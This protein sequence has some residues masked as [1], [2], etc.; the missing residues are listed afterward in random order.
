MIRIYTSQLKVI[1]GQIRENFSRMEKEIGC[2]R[3]NNADIVVF[4]E[5]CVSGY[6]IGDLWDQPSFLSELK[7]YNEKLIADSSSMTII[8]GSAAVDAEKINTDGRVRKYN[9]AFVASGGRLL[10][11]D[12]CS[13]PFVVKTLLP[14]YRQF[15]DRRY[16]TSALELAREMNT[17]ACDQIA[18]VCIPVNDGVFKAGILLCEDSWDENYSIHPMQILAEKKADLLINLSASPFTLHKNEKRHRMLKEAAR[19]FQIPI[20]YVNQRGV[21][22]NGKGVYTFDG[23][24]A[25]YDQDGALLAEAAP[26]DDASLSFAFDL[27]TKT[28]TPEQHKPP[29]EGSML[30]PA[31]RYGVKHFLSSI[32]ADKVVIGISG[33]IDSAVNAA[34]YRSVLPEENVLLVNTPTKY[35]SSLTKN[36]AEELATN[37]SS[38]YAVLPIGQFT[39]D[40]IAS[41][42]KIS[43]QKGNT[44]QL[45]MLSPVMQENIRAR[46]RSA[47]VLA[48][49]SS[50]FGGIF[51]CNSNKTELSIGYGTLYGDLAG[52]LAA[53]GDLWKHQI[54]ELGRELNAYF[55]HPI[56]PE[57]CFTIRPSA[58]LSDTQDITKGFGDPLIYDYHDYLFQ[59]FTEPWERKT[60]EDILKWYAEGTL[61]KHIATPLHIADI[62][63]TAK[64]FITDLEHWWHLFS[65]FAVA[66]RIQAPPLIAISRR[67]FGY[68]LRES[69][70]APYLT[71]G[72]YEMKQ[73]LLEK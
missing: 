37:L 65:G 69:Q 4:P 30:L 25:A 62:F 45:L 60:P 34:L 59:S 27:E 48:G 72:Y 49:L 58:E 42:Q 68:D 55:G 32:H 41:L 11:P 63:P 33:G 23:M 73:V 46:D 51:T 13:R 31:L 40:T 16:F 54:Y 70:V 15:D 26:Y 29:Y 38:P 5:L 21:Q 36:L 20:L 61:E 53:T 10:S 14:S 57:G 67:P 1:P 7:R 44:N 66:K 71:D 6:L 3:E 64:E 18:P 2:A 17:P 22:N 19:R 9:A 35:N 12:H 50:A 8:W 52:A 24:T 47:R 43:I 28:L 56:I 39:D